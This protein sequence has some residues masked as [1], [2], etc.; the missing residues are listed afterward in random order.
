MRAIR[1]ITETRPP[2]IGVL[3]LLSTSWELKHNPLTV[4]SIY[5]KQ[6]IIFPCTKRFFHL[7]YPI[8]QDNP[9]LILLSEL[10]KESHKEYAQFVEAVEII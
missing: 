5:T 2:N 3:F 10:Y 4:E 9:I 6:Q 1:L 8:I 7:D